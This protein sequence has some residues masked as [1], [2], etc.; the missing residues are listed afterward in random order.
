[1]NNDGKSVASAKGAGGLDRRFIGWLKTGISAGLDTA[2]YPGLLAV[3]ESMGNQMVD[4][5]T[6][7]S[8]RQRH[9]DKDQKTGYRCGGRRGLTRQESSRPGY[10]K[11]F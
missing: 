2:I 7:D 11:S 9:S 6:G 5:M 3:A 8:V 1:M 4:Q 10:T